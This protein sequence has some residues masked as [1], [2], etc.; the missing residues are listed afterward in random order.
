MDL[1]DKMA[2]YVRVIEAG[3]LSAAAKQLRISS[4]AVSRQLATLERELGAPLVLRT[5]RS[6]T[7]T[8][9]GRRYYERCLGILRDVDDAQA[10]G[11]G[12][13]VSGILKINAPISFGL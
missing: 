2:T 7:I 6:M 3:N 5:T 4:A 10:I 9:V 11:R 13:A 8:P 1:L 12:T